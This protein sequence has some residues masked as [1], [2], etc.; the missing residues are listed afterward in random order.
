M[1]FFRGFAAAF[2]ATEPA[3]IDFLVSG[4]VHHTQFVSAREIHLVNNFF[5]LCAASENL[6]VAPDFDRF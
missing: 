4:I 3:A 6:V 1:L 5:G 2:E